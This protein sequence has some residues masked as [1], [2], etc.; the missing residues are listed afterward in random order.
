MVER[1]G[2]DEGATG[3]PTAC[4]PHSFRHRGVRSRLGSRGGSPAH[5]DLWVQCVGR[6][7]DQDA[8]QRFLV[9]RSFVR[10]DGD[11]LL[12]IMQPSHP[13]PLLGHRKKGII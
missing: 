10:S 7:A 6:S 9:L 2:T 11:G 4:D 8:G 12:W 13:A 3:I 1:W 5:I